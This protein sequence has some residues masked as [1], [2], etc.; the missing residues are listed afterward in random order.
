MKIQFACAN[1][2]N[3]FDVD[4]LDIKLDK[5]GELVFSPLPECP[6]CGATEEVVLSNYGLEQIDDLV[7]SNKIKIIK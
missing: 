2:L 3:V 1:C 4:M 6:E 7:F 5:T